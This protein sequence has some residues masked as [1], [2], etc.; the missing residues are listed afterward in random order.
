MIDFDQD[1]TFGY[2]ALLCKAVTFSGRRLVLSPSY[3]RS[4]I[5]D[6]A[7]WSH[8]IIAFIQVSHSDRVV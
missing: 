4:A 3:L 7:I 1:A 2:A 5:A 6:R 8:F